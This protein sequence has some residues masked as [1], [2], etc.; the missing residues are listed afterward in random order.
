MSKFSQGSC[1]NIYSCI[2]RGNGKRN[3]VIRVKPNS[4][5]RFALFYINKCTAAVL[6]VDATLFTNISL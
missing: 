3:H 5:R 6:F 1:K 4:I 2:F